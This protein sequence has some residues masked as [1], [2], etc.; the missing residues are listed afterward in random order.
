MRI[1]FNNIQITFQEEET[2]S[3]KSKKVIE[4]RN[5]NELENFLT[6]L[7][8]KKFDSDVILSSKKVEKLFS[9]LKKRHK[10]I[11]AAGGI[12]VNTNGEYL[13]IK[14]L[15]MWDLPKGKVK[16]NE[17]FKEGAKREVCE[18]TGLKSVKITKRLPDTW[19]IYRRK[20]EWHLKRTKWYMMKVIEEGKLKPQI[21]ED[22]TEVVWMNN[23][24]AIKAISTS[25]RSIV[26]ELGANF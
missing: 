9:K 26:E 17:K 8:N 12:A 25:Y 1:Y 5:S 20:K 21:E 13:L 6:K 18:E 15:G 3:D 10:F 23:G 22:I 7:H 24:D 4:I 19:H 14:R 2:L 11:R 16:K